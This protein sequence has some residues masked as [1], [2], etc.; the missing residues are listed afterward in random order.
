MRLYVDSVSKFTTSG[1]KLSTSMSLS[2]GTHHVSVVAY[3]K[4]GSSLKTSETIT[5]H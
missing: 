5:V 1:S 4:N 3:E 2:A